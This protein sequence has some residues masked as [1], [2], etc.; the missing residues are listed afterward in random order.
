MVKTGELTAKQATFVELYTA[1]GSTTYNNAMQS[2]LKA[3][4]AETTAITAC[5]MIL[6]KTRVKE[7]IAEARVANKAGMID[8]VQKIRDKHMQYMLEAELAG[9]KALARLNLQDL[10]R[11]YA[12]YTDKA[13]IDNEFTLNIQRFTKV[14]ESSTSGN[15]PELPENGRMPQTLPN[16]QPSPE[17]ATIEGGSDNE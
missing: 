11:T 15:A 2:A 7:A 10:G 4:Y 5:T 13:V 9:D 6:D 1:I 17:Q 3:G 14:I 12:A 8:S 16:T